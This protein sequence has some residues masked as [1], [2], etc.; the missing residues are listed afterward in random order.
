MQKKGLRLRRKKT[1]EIVIDREAGLVFPS[2][3]ALVDHFRGPIEQLEQEYSSLV[4]P[5]DVREEDVKNLEDQLD[6][7]LEQPAEIWH[8]AQTFA[9]FPVFHFV[10]PID[11]LDAFHIAVAYVNSEDEPSFIFL[12]FVTRHLELVDNYRRGDLVYDLAFE[13]V[14][15]GMLDGDALTEGDPLAMGLF[16]AMLKLR[17]DKDVPYDKF[18]ACGEECREDTIQNA[19]EIWRSTDLHGNQIVTF[20]KEFPD[21]EIRDLFYIA[22]TQEDAGSQVH[23]LL[24]SFPTNDENLVDRYRHGENLQAEEVSQESSH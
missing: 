14:G 10:R 16:I 9:D 13:E 18:L 12:H 11:E 23:S 22:I 1:K 7:T 3:K 19:D 15:F 2:E 20:I 24:F 4:R 5:D 8:D 21:S 6:L 17:G